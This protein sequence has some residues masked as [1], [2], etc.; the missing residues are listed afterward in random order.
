MMLRYAITNRTLLPRSESGHFPALIT[1]AGQWAAR[2]LDYIQIRE[3]DLAPGAL[4]E[5]TRSIVSAVREHSA[6]TR[7]LLNGPA[8]IALEAG[9]DGVHLPASATPNA[10]AEARALF[11]RSG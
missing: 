9:A 4:D 11:A 7:I 1:L 10:A 6:R 8:E 3:K 2:N 5:L